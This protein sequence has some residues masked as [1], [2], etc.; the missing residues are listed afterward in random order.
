MEKIEI[1]RLAIVDVAKKYIGQQEIPGNKGFVDT[2]FEK[3]MRERG[4]NTG[5]SWCAYTA[6]L[7]WKEGYD[8]A[9]PF[10]A[11][12]VANMFSANAV[13]TYNNLIAN[14]FEGSLVPEQGDIALWQSYKNGVPVQKGEW[15]MGHMAIVIKGGQ[16]MF[17]TVEGNSNSKGEREGIEVASKKRTYSFNTN[18]GLR[19]VGFIKPKYLKN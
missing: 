14:G 10:V 11:L 6:E 9:N 1:L 8:K 19:L 13:R 4:W 18:T 17:E 7:I 12:K 16:T 3:K 15:Y 5:E 2:H